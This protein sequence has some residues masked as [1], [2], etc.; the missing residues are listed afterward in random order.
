[1]GRLAFRTRRPSVNPY[2]PFA[3]QVVSS[4]RFALLLRQLVCSNS[5]LQRKLQSTPCYVKWG[6]GAEF[7]QI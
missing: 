6:S 7:L 5:A 4:M 2:L 1:M 3:L